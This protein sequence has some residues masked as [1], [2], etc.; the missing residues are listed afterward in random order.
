MKAAGFEDF[1]LTGKT[2]LVTGGATGIGFSMTRALARAGAKVMIAARRED[3]LKNAAQELRRDPLIS[4]LPHHVV[5]LGD[6]ASVRLLAEHA[7]ATMGGVDI[8]IGNAAQDFLEPLEAIRDESI[9]KILQ[10]NVSANVE[11]FRAF[12]PYMRK[13]QW[14]RVIFS[15]SA[16]TICASA[17]DRMS[18]YVATKG[19]LNAFTKAAAAE[20]GHDGITVNCLVLGMFYTDLIR[21]A[22]ALTDKAQ[23]PAAAAA[24]LE[25]FASMTSVGRL[26]QCKEIEGIIQL[27]ASNAGSYI[28]ATNLLVDGGLSSMLRPHAT[29]N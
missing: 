24:F 23:G 14:G 20:T 16:S 21:E 11:L 13:K 19:A 28:T 3:V 4:E 25:T 26:A 12:L 6:R 2:A 1:D 8:F 5:D 27:L 9:D 17:T 15:S 29:K 7:I 22:I 18:M 10:V